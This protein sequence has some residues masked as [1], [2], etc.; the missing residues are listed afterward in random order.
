MNEKHKRQI[1]RE[2]LTDFE[3]SFPAFALQLEDL[4]KDF[5]DHELSGFLVL[6]VEAMGRRDAG[7]LD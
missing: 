4:R 1:L 5:D 2:V 3:D 6:V 7:L